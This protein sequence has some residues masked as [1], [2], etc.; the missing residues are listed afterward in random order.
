[1]LLLCNIATKIK[2]MP[3]IQ[4]EKKK[5]TGNRSCTG[6]RSEEKRQTKLSYPVNQLITTVLKTEKTQ[7]GNKDLELQRACM[8]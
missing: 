5:D 2:K 3:K 6:F 8:L 7:E 4:L 1:M